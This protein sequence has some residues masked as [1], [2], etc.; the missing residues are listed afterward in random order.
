MS[1]KKHVFPKCT[2]LLHV[3][4]L[5]CKSWASH[6]G[7]S[8]FFFCT[9]HGSNPMLNITNVK[10]CH[11]FRC[12][13]LT[14]ADFALLSCL[15]GQNEWPFWHF[16]YIHR[17]NFELMIS[18]QCINNEWEE[19]D[20]TETWR[21]EL[22]EEATMSVPSVTNEVSWQCVVFIHCMCLANIAQQKNN[23]V[24]TICCMWEEMDS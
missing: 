10:L 20:L 5:A 24:N 22:T 8:P 12:D 4:R 23:I 15:F 18:K 16:N 3:C 17:H 6:N 11:F 7:C 14:K 13:C 19:E 1:S 2:C 9:C 21:K